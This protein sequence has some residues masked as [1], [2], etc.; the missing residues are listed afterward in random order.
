LPHWDRSLP[1]LAVAILL[2]AAICCQLARAQDFSAQGQSTLVAE[3][4]SIGGAVGQRNKTIS[5]EEQRSPDSA[6]GRSANSNKEDSLPKSIQLK[7]RASG[8]NYTITLH[9]AGG[10]NYQGIWSNG[11][12]AKFTVTAFTKNSVK[13]ERTDNPSLGSVTG[14]YTGTRT[15]NRANGEA[16]I[17]NGT[18]STWDA[19]W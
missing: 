1:A 12:G 17:S 9:S 13:M 18:I 6:S 5:G 15:G 8:V 10:G 3:A 4:G 19:S 7:E 14:S 11:Y 2:A 16:S